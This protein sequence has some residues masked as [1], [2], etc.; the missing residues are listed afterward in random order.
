M[1]EE[2]ENHLP[3]PPAGYPCPDDGPTPAAPSK[4]S[5]TINQYICILKSY[6]S[7]YLFQ[8]SIC[9]HSSVPHFTT[10]YNK[11]VTNILVISDRGVYCRKSVMKTDSL[12]VAQ[13]GSEN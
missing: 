9:S 12:Q 7:P 5:T 11:I 10:S 1:K 13:F 4:T 8:E 3:V 2:G 6:S